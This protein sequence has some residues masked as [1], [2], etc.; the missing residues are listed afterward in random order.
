MS[1]IKRF[2]KLSHKF[3]TEFDS[4]PAYTYARLKSLIYN[5]LTLVVPLIIN[6]VVGPVI[7]CGGGP[8]KITSCICSLINVQR[9][10]SADSC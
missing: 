9:V 7:L 8:I 2:N 6:F 10:I 3:K 4:L 1:Q 5:I